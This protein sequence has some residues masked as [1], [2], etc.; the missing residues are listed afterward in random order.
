MMLDCV[1]RVEQFV[2]YRSGFISKLLSVKVDDAEQ[3]V[4]ARLLSAF[5][6]YVSKS[7][8]EPGA[9]YSKNLCPEKR[10][11]TGWQS[12]CHF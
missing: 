10:W 12:N 8:V 9:I 6:K 11:I 3:C 2:A 1:Y 7:R 4:Q 5:L